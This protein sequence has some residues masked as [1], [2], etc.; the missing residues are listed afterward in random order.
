MGKT[1]EV[2]AGRVTNPGAAPVALTP[3]T[4]DSF[5]V[6]AT[7][8]GGPASLRGIWSQNATGGPVRVRSPRLHDVTQGIRFTIPAGVIRNELP[9]TAATPVYPQDNLIFELGGGAAETDCAAL[10]LYYENLGGMD[11][12]LGMWAQIQPMIVEMTT[13]EVAVPGPAAA[14]DWSAGTAINV[15]N[16]LL[17]ANEDYAILG[18][19]CDTACLAVAIK[20][21]DTGN[22]RVGG[23]GPIEPVETRDWFV[24]LSVDG[25]IPAIPVINQA[26]RGATLAHVAK[27]TAAGTVNVDLIVARLS[28]RFNG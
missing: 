16:D 17:K 22:A 11:A 25:G 12:R 24:S 15:T 3:N 18:Y 21:P 7:S 5:A 14:G 20:G 26:N 10:L 2:I 8:D 6:R 4:G 27:A 19:A 23:P 13:V 28:G 9:D 1:L